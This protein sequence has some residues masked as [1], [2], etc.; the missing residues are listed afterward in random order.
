[1]SDDARRRKQRLIERIQIE[2]AE[3]AYEAALEV[4]RDKK[5]PPA[6]RSSAATSILRAGG[7]FDRDATQ[8]GD[9]QPHEMTA[10]QLNDALAEIASRRNDESET[11]VFS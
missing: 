10:Q 5:A 7:Y 3:A 2:G 4:C 1:M 11:D 9:I 8:L 6:A